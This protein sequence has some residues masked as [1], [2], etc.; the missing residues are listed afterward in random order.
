MHETV[1]PSRAPSIGIDFGTAYSCVA[2]FRHG[3][4]EII[5]NDR[6]NLKTPSCV[7]FT[8]KERLIGEA[9]L[10]QAVDNPDNTIFNVKRLIGRRFEDEVVQ[11]YRKHWPLTVVL[12]DRRLKIQVIYKGKVRTFFPEEVSSMILAKLK[13]TAEA[14]LGCRIFNAV[15]SV[16]ANFNDAQRQATKD[17]AIIAGL[18]VLRI[19]NEPTAAAITYALS[20]PST[21]GRHILV[22]DFGAGTFDASVL[23]IKGKD[24]KVLATSGNTHLGGEDIDNRMV[25][26]FVAEF[27]RRHKIDPSSDMRALR[28][29]RTAWELAKIMLSPSDETSSDIAHPEE[30]SSASETLIQIDSLFGGIDF[31]T[32]ITQARFNESCSELFELTITH[33]EN[34]LRDANLSKMAIEDII[35]VGG[36]SRILRVQQYLKDLFYGKE[37]SQFSQMGEAVARGT[38]AQ[39]AVMTGDAAETL[40]GLAFFDVT[41]H[42]LG[43]EATDGSMETLITRNTTIPAWQQDTIGSSRK[44]KKVIPIEIYEGERSIAKENNLLGTFEFNFSPTPNSS[45]CAFEILYDVDANGILTLS[46]GKRLVPTKETVGFESTNGQ[47]GLTITPSKDR[48]SNEEI[49][50]IIQQNKD[51]ENRDT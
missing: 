29:L 37:L 38:A 48:L 6:G 50:R 12:E 40:Q 39:A 20:P 25:D 19:I 2:V 28:R 26:Q 21:V 47:G 4:A 27:H 30:L 8:E 17:A 31:F 36:S 1:K 15:I 34:A 7:A 32:S 10:E 13:V 9:A 14:Y 3:K 23:S 18:S 42:S 16:P 35:L 49:A 41:P 44:G 24:L 46:Q 51:E 43:I 45:S 11:N 33:V 5:P 22:Y